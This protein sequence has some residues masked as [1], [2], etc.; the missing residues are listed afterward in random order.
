M[1]E[2]QTI[3]TSVARLMGRGVVDAAGNSCGTVQEFAVDVS[4]DQT[5]VAGLV[6]RQRKDGKLRRTLLPVSEVS[7]PEDGEAVLKAKEKPKTFV[8]TDD[9][10]LLDYDVLDQ[11]IID[12]NGRKVVRV[13]DV[14]LVWEP[15]KSAAGKN[16]AD[17]TAGATGLRIEEVEVGTRGATR[18]LFKGLPAG[19]VEGISGQF[20]PRSIP[21]DCVDLIERDPARRVRLKIGQE[22]LSK[23]H[24]SDIAEILEELA[25]VERDAVFSSLPEETAAEALEE[26]EP[27]LQKA[28]LQGLDSERAADI[29]EEMDPGAAADVLAELSD[30][31]SEAILEEMEPEER[32]D[33]EELLEFE[34]H[35]AA[36]AMT[37]DYVSA[38]EDG[39]VADAVAALREFEGDA[40]TVTEVYLLGEEGK[41]KGVVTLTKL[42][43]APSDTP[44]ATLADRHNMSCGLHATEKE[45]AALFDKYNLRSLAVV[46]AHKRMAGVIH[47]EQ[48]IAQLLEG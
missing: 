33:V 24:P 6:L 13:N 14:N 35:S 16:A 2:P 45:V 40:D 22:R 41:L 29:L 21:W 12:V 5:R 18:R 19:M 48:V 36:G 38:A 4:V 47:A 43:L 31:E 20:K 3:S 34:S 7:W 37:T 11:Q 32:Q 30:E 10:L 17:N 25:P 27:K 1:L 9:Y 44:L 8:K 46:D 23:L 42:L 15:G 26:V 39:T 28:L